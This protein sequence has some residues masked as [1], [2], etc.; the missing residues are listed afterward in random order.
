M[1]LKRFDADTLNEIIKYVLAFVM[2]IL[3][4]AFLVAVQGESPVIAVKALF[5]GTFGSKRKAILDSVSA[6][7]ILDDYLAWR[8]EHPGEI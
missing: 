6:T 1:K 5:S 8:R 2:V 3:I 4:G 7:V